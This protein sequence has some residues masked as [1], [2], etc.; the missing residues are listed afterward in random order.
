M[1][2]S[3]M[4]RCRDCRVVSVSHRAMTHSISTR[5]FWR[6]QGWKLWDQRHLTAIGVTGGP[7]DEFYDAKVQV[8]SEMSK[9]H[10]KEEEKRAEA[11][12]A[13][14]KEAGLN[15]D[16]L[17]GQLRARKADLMKEYKSG[18]PTPQTRSFKGT[19]L[20]TAS[21]SV[22]RPDPRCREGVSPGALS[23]ATPSNEGHILRLLPGAPFGLSPSRPISRISQAPSHISRWLSLSCGCCGRL[24]ANP[25][26]RSWRSWLRVSYSCLCAS[27]P[28]IASCSSAGLLGRFLA[29]C[30]LAPSTRFERL[31]LRS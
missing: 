1:R 24:Y 28:C 26:C 18:L 19:E 7:D 17:G 10:V 5:P 12:F 31:L 15:M 2:R 29:G 14:A 11:M 6:S 23:R 8:L 9:Y 13:E 4:R 27:K 22:K 25:P 20:E 21:P 3:Y 16:A 30:R